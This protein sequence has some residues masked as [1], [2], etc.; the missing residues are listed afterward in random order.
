MNRLH[1]KWLVASVLATA[2]VAGCG[3]DSSSSPGAAPPPN[4][5]QSAQGVVDFILALI[6]SSTTDLA[7]PIDINPLTLAADDLANPSPI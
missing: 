5:S 3:G 6:A 2:L 4:P 7:E 1:S